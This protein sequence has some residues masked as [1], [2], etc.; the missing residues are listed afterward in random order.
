MKFCKSSLQKWELKTFSGLIMFDLKKVITEIKD[1][2]IDK[3]FVKELLDDVRERRKQQQNE[4]DEKRK[5][6]NRWKKENEKM[7]WNQK[8]KKDFKEHLNHMTI[9]PISNR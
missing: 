4:A 2:E 6:R 3:N 7:R 1:Y 9:S 5:Q 8:G